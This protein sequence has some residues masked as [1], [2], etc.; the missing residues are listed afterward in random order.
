MGRN[1]FQSEFA[2]AMIQA[3]RGVVH[4]GLSPAEA[5]DLLQT[6]KSERQGGQ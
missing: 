2:A 4:D 5:F 1:I 3:V 6:L